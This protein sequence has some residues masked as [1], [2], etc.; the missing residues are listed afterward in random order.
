MTI[1][2]EMADQLTNLQRSSVVEKKNLPK[3]LEPVAIISTQ[4]MSPGTPQ[5]SQTMWYRWVWGSFNWKTKSIPEA[6]S[7][8]NDL[9]N[10][11]NHANRHHFESDVSNMNIKITR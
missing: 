8:Y 11:Y 9:S 10:I 6:S 4:F 3:K 5:A 7:I 1:R 2:S